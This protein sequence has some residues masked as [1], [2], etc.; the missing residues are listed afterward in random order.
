MH[1]TVRVYTASPSLA[2]ALVAHEGDVRS[3]ISEIDGFSAYYLI[4]TADGA[5]SVSVYES[6]SGTEES[7]QAAAAWIKDNLPELAGASP[8][9]SAGEVVIHI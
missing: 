1:A 2:D 5:V 8:Q 6:Q 3:L 4:K 7:N 9:I